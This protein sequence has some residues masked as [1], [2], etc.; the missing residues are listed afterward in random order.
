VLRRVLLV[1]STSCRAKKY[2]SGGRQSTRSE[3]KIRKEVRKYVVREGAGGGAFAQSQA[4]TVAKNPGAC[5][6]RRAHFA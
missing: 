2:L 3:R 6:H 1:P 5:G 4:G